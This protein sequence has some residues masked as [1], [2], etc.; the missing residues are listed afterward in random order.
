MSKVNG[1]GAQSQRVRRH[2]AGACG[3]A[4]LVGLAASGGAVWAGHGGYPYNGGGVPPEL[5]PQL[6]VQVADMAESIQNLRRKHG[7]EKDD[8]AETL[9]YD[10]EGAWVSPMEILGWVWRTVPEDAGERETVRLAIRRCHSG[11]SFGPE[12]DV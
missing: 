7:W 5:Q 10:D 11:H 3:V 9:G 6:C 8:V 12:G 4:L 1:M 2:A